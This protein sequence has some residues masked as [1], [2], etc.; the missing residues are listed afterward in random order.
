ME[1]QELGVS[2]NPVAF[3]VIQDDNVKLMPVNHSSCVDKLLDYIPDLMQR[4]N[5]MMNK[6]ADNKKEQTEKVIREM[7]KRSKEKE[8]ED[9]D[10]I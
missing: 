5:K 8:D 4:T 2:I 1:E 10:L 6:M 7:Q 3:I 9:D